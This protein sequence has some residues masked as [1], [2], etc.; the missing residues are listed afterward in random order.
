[1]KTES[2][3]LLTKYPAGS[4]REIASLAWPL[5]IT[6]MSGNLMIFVDR[7][8]LSWYSLEAMNAIA[9]IAQVL[10]VFQF[11][12][13]ALT[14][15]SEVFVGRYNGAQ[16]YKKIGKPVWQMMW[17]ALSLAVIYIPI[18]IFAWPLIPQEFQKEGIP[19]FQWMMSFSFLMP[20]IG[21]L[22]GFYAGRG[23]VKILSVVALISNIMNGVLSAVLLFGIKGFIPSFGTRGAAFGTILAQLFYFGV[24][25]CIFLKG[26]NRTMYQTHKW[27]FQKKLFRE[28]VDIGLPNSIS[29]SIEFGG[30]ALVTLLVASL[31]MEYAT[32]NNIAVSIFVL[33]N[34][35]VE[36]LQKSVIA[37]ASNLIGAERDGKI[38]RAIKSAA[39]FQ[40]VLVLITSLP[41]VFFSSYL[42]RLFIHDEATLDLLLRPTQIAVIF[43]WLYFS[44]DGMSW[45]FAAVLTAAGDTKFIMK[46]N[47]VTIF[48]FCLFPVYLF[49]YLQKG[50]Y[51]LPWAISA[52]YSSV[53]F[54]LFCWRY[55]SNIWRENLDPV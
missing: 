46:T 3:K 54:S 40:G 38:N 15:I 4:T 10:C 22:A 25:F 1:M 21:A 45:I 37:I 55:K 20:M 31:G 5:M 32:V 17:L 39:K 26:E 23:Q 29:H 48:L 11:A 43:V 16:D 12:P 53:N 2:F 51:Y 8:L 14:S 50:P 49:V 44:I 52:F 24:L 18:G 13:I 41:L 28:C 35:L 6:I 42:I 7:W 33:F 34:F 47:M 19:Y 27:G 36:A 30:W 9:V